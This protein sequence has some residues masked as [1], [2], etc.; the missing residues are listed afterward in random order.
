MA[1]T[2]WKSLHGDAFTGRRAL[3]TGAAGFIGSHLCEALTTLGAEVVALD[4][5]SGSDGSWA[6]LNTFFTGRQVTGTIL[7][8]DLVADAMQGCDLVFH[9]AAMGSVPRSVTMPRRYHENNTTGTL[10]VLEAARAAGVSRVM[11]AASS[12]AYGDTPTLPKT[13]TMPVLPRSPYAANKV[14]CEALMRAYAIS[15]A[16]GTSNTS[17]SGVET[18]G[19]DTVNLRYFNIFGPR[20]NANSAYAAVIAAFATALLNGK[21]P[22]IYGDGEQSR[23]F[24]F[25]DNAVHANLLAARAEGQLAGTVCNVACGQRVSVNQLAADMAELLGKP[26]LKP[27]HRE[28]RTGDVKHSLADLDH[29]RATLGYEPIV[30]FK[31]GLAATVEWYAAESKR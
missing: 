7:D 24:T 13:E 29:T 12:S 18:S 19:V 27:E 17:E 8:A 28:A 3:V 6:N 30:D 25:I 22:A 2:D 21:R 1:L 16:P 23:D 14:A 4:D 9:Q 31:D 10:N 11:F 20:Q 15:Y 26:E 5:L